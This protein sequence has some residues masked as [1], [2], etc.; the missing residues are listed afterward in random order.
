MSIVAPTA[1]AS[2]VLCTPSSIAMAVDWRSSRRES[3]AIVNEM[4]IAARLRATA[5]ARTV[6]RF[7]DTR[8]FSAT[9]TPTTIA[10]KTPKAIFWNRGWISAIRSGRRARSHIPIE[11][12]ITVI[13][14]TRATTPSISTSSLNPTA[15]KWS[16]ATDRK[17]GTVTTAA[18]LEIPVIEIE[19]AVSP[20][21]RWV[22]RFAIVP[23][24]EAPSSTMPTAS[25]GSSENSSAMPK[26]SSGEMIARF[27]IPIEMPFG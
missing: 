19:S 16:I 11:R 21:A 27:R 14:S 20:R 10:R 26:A 23:P 15:P 25:A 9:I 2:A 4:V 22:S 18:T 17:R 13:A 6:S 24:G 8:S 3:R 5:A 1:I 12:G 7:S